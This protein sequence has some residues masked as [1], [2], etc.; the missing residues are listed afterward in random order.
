M[1]RFFEGFMG[2]LVKLRMVEVIYVDEVP[3]TNA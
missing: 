2:I 3:D 1:K